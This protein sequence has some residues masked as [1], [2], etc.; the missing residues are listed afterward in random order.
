[1]RPIARE[2]GLEEIVSEEPSR[3]DY[4]EALQALVDADAVLL[5]GT[6]ER[7]YMPSKAFPA[8]VSERP[9]LALYHEASPVVDLLRRQGSA[10]IRLVTYGDRDPAGGQVDRIARALEQLIDA[11]CDRRPF[12]PAALASSSAYALAGRLAHVL[13][14]VAHR[15]TTCARSA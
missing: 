5:L 13:D 14:A 11:P 8:L 12:D 3:L 7:H 1:V 4:F 9:L 10:S 6:S 15:T 2:L